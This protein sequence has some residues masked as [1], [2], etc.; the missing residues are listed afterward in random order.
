MPRCSPQAISSSM[1]SGVGNFTCLSRAPAAAVEPRFRRCFAHSICRQ[2][3][4]R[5]QTSWGYAGYGCEICS[6]VGY[7]MLL[8]QCCSADVAPQ[9]PLSLSTPGML[10]T[11][12]SSC[13]CSS[14]QTMT[15]WT[16]QWQ[17]RGG[18]G[19]HWGWVCVVFIFPAMGQ[20]ML[21]TPCPNSTDTALSMLYTLQM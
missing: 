18:G 20:K 19:G 6:G 2:W 16:T 10:P 15:H 11:S 1:C 4:R 7:T 14:S 12:Q 21:R 17:V 13:A 5:M 9:R 3:H 8:C